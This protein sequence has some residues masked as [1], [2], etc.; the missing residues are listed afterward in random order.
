[1]CTTFSVNCGSHDS[2]GRE[3]TDLSFCMNIPSLYKPF[4]SKQL[5]F[6][7]DQV[8]IHLHY[9]KVSSLLPKGEK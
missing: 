4:L 6:K 1:M 8:P 9:M 3:G 5:C 2:G 7:L